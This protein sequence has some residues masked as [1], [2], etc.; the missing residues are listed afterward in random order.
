MLNGSVMVGSHVVVTTDAAG[1]QDA[2]MAAIVQLEH[3]GRYVP[4]LVP[5]DCL[6]QVGHKVELGMVATTSS[7]FDYTIFQIVSQLPS[8][9]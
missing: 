3:N 4:A 8:R 6:V 5:A 9:S 7:A 2:K 1:K